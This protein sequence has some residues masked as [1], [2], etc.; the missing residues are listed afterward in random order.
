MDTLRRP[1]IDAKTWLWLA[2][3]LLLCAGFFVALISLTR[4][5]TETTVFT[6][7]WPLRHVL[8]C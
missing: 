7:P 1:H 3:I 6:L 2:L 8:Y 5:D 4:I